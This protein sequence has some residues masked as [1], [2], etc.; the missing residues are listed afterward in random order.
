[1]L[2]QGAN[3]GSL[4]LG[5]TEIQL[6]DMADLRKLIEGQDYD[7][8]KRFNIAK[9]DQVIG[10]VEDPITNLSGKDKNLLRSILSA[11][12]S[13]QLVNAKVQPYVNKTTLLIVYAVLAL[14]LVPVAH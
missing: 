6:R 3:D 11:S 10:D 7:L 9:Y 12:A 4:R 13:D 8:A 14:A 1:M 5:D 2:F